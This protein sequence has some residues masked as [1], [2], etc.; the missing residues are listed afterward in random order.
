MIVFL[1]FP[2][3]SCTQRDVSFNNDVFEHYLDTYLTYVD[4]TGYIKDHD[5]VIV[6]CSTKGDT[7]LISINKSG[8]AY[9]LIYHMPQFVDY[10]KYNRYDI[11]LVGHFPNDVI[12]ISKN[13][14]INV[15]EDIVRVNYPRDYQVYLQ[16]PHWVKP[17]AGEEMELVVTF[18]KDRFISC[19]RNYFG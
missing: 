3:L 2:L 6:E 7:I 11:L 1:S 13:K 19:K 9:S 16:D 5:F 17:L 10:F 4:S 18:Y 14:E 15:I 8:G 12:H